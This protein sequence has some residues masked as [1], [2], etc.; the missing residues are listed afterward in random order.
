MP[1]VL[2][3]TRKETF[4][5]A[6]CCLRTQSGSSRETL[7]RKTRPRMKCTAERPHADQEKA[8]RILEIAIAVEP[9]QGRIHVEK[10]NETFLF[11]DRDSPAEYGAGLKLA[12]ERG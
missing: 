5:C 11:C 3:T 4:G 6:R 7:I 2:L 12:I 9:V 10:I 1:V 8:R